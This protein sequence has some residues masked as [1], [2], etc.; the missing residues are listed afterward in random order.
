MEHTPAAWKTKGSPT[1]Q[2]TIG[3][4]PSLAKGVPAMGY[5]KLLKI[6]GIL[7]LRVYPLLRLYTPQ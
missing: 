5:F 6:M 7:S 4:K 2:M 3:H 1:A